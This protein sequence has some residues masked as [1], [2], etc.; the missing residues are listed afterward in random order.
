MLHSETS[1]PIR[2]HSSIV[3][4]RLDEKEGVLLHLDTKRYYSLNET[5]AHLWELLEGGQCA[6]E[7][8][9]ALLLTYHITSE[10]AAEVVQDFVGTLQD[11]GL[12]KI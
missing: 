3:F 6:S 11:N 4:I 12:I 8:V 7:L 10:E 9:Q 5:D 2:P 1:T